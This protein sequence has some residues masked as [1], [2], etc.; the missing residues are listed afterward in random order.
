MG[1][2]LNDT[3]VCMLVSNDSI[4]LVYL[5]DY[6]NLYKYT[7]TAVNY[8]KAYKERNL[9]TLANC[10]SSA[11]KYDDEGSHPKSADMAGVCPFR[12]NYASCHAAPPDP[13]TDNKQRLDFQ[14]MID[15]MSFLLMN[16]CVSSDVVVKQ[17]LLCKIVV[18]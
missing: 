16:V 14:L 2:A 17:N 7:L 6:G 9:Q 3:G 10:W 1:S 5:N 15:L 4:L 8:Q 12:D 13:V 11:A 18:I